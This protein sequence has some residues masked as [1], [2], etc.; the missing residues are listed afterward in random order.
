MK[1]SSN[2]LGRAIL[3]SALI[4]AGLV[5]TGCEHLYYA[6]PTATASG[7]TAAQDITPAATPAVPKPAPAR[8]VKTPPLETQ[9]IGF[10]QLT[11]APVSPQPL[12]TPQPFVPPSPEPP[13]W[14]A[15]KPELPN[16]A[17]SGNVIQVGDLLTVTFSDIPPPGLPEFKERVREDGNITLPLSITLK[18]AGKNTFEFF[19]RISEPQAYPAPTP[20]QNT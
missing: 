16:P 4:A 7:G 19:S 1:P 18:A 12:A 2:C 9:P 13:V 11:P 6:D 20:Q 3:A 14:V 8:R 17:A 5:L 10:P 15:P